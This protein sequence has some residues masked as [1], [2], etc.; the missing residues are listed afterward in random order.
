MAQAEGEIKDETGIWIL[1]QPKPGTL[2]ALFMGDTVT[3]SL[4]SP[5][6]YNRALNTAGF[7]TL[8]CDMD[9]SSA[10]HEADRVMFWPGS[11]TL[12]G[13]PGE[14]DPSTALLLQDTA[15]SQE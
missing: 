1:L 10:L 8:H 2:H 4:L 3:L 11:G 9:R 6:S 7:E 15:N 5:L 13:K 14:R 12:Q